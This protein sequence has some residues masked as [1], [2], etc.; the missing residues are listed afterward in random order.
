MKRSRTVKRQR[1]SQAEVAELRQA[2]IDFCTEHQPLSVRN[3]YYLMAQAQL[4]PKTD[5][6]YRLVMEQSGKAALKPAR[7]RLTGCGMNHAR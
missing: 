1:R 6:G 4:V 7:S 2:M 3:L 5:K